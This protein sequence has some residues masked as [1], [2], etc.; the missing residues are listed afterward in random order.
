M[1]IRLSDIEFGLKLRFNAQSF[2]IHTEQTVEKIDYL[3]AG[4][5]LSPPSLSGDTAYICGFQ[6]LLKY[7]PQQIE[8][9]LICVVDSRSEASPI[10]FKSR[11][12]LV[13]YHKSIAEVMLEISN[14]MYRCGTKSSRLLDISKEFLACSSTEMLLAQGFSHLGN[15]LIVTNAE[16]CI[17]AYTPDTEVINP[18]YEEVIHLEH[19]PVGHPT[20]GSNAFSW[21][22]PVFQFSDKGIAE[23]P[24]VICRELKLNGVLKGYLHLLD[25]NHPFLDDDYQVMELL[26]NLLTISI[27]VNPDENHSFQSGNTAEKFLRDILD[28][29]LSS[30]EE[31]EMVQGRLK[32]KT[33]ASVYAIIIKALTLEQ[34]P[35]KSFF[36]LSRKLSAL[37]TDSHCFLYRNSIFIVRFCNV[38]EDISSD[39]D[40]IKP[41]LE[42]NHLVAGVS[43]PIAS[44][45]QLRD[46]GYQANNALYLGSH[47]SKDSILYYKDFAIDHMI[48]L[49]LAKEEISSFITP[50]L[51]T[52][53]NYCNENNVDFLHTLRAY[54][55]NNCSKSATAKVLYMHINTLKYQI[56]RMEKIMGISI[57]DDTNPFRLM[58][59]FRLLDYVRNFHPDNSL[60]L[61]LFELSEYPR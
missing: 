58:M 13:V 17:I 32:L 37:L 1:N 27:W 30:P 21:A 14:V 38:G 23:L 22:G 11:C 4:D 51:V 2:N 55:E 36:K 5:R 7:D 56:D 16:Q 61:G 15:P 28:D 31:I 20:V 47:H 42:A 40:R 53:M 50:E 54:L 8:A 44:L 49:C 60:P 45:V 24:S 33:T 39:L 57:K 43:N 52:V 46:A 10:Y 12:V 3:P 35:R 9:P 26:G 6:T 25:F 18:V 41:L 29:K 59:S 19:L 34:T 48:R